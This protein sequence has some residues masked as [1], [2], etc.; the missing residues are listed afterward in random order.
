MIRPNSTVSLHSSISAASG[1]V[2]IWGAGGH[3][4]V[5]A[6]IIADNPRIIIEGFLD[7]VSPAR[8]GTSLYGSTIL[9]DL[10]HLGTLYP[11]RDVFVAL[12]VGNN[13]ARMSALVAL[14]G[15]GFPLLTVISSTASVSP[16]VHIG[17]GVVIMPQV[18]IN[19][20]SVIGDAAVINTGS[21]VD[22]D[23]TIEEGVH[24][25]PG[26]HLAGSCRVERGAFVGIGS[27]VRD[28]ITI[29][30]NTVIGAGSVVVANIPS[31]VT[32]YGNPARV[33][34]PHLGTTGQ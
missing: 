27:C 18:A 33:V 29:G 13:R 12:A 14:R 15:K 11:S 25:A 2:V 28:A 9:G 23:C 31:G 21:T 32:A 24:L 10:A 5:V 16:S 7:D 3:A 20:D 19:A 4:K 30:N 8:W 34:S 17:A 26:V 6:D 1:R 22:H